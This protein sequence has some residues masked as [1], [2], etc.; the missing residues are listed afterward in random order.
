MHFI[1][2][3]RGT[4][5]EN[6]ESIPTCRENK[7]NTLKGRFLMS[8][9]HST[10]PPRFQKGKKKKRERNRRRRVGREW[11]ILRRS[12]EDPAQRPLSWGIPFAIVYNSNSDE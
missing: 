3:R 10:A 1:P 7:K 11:R 6:D 8:S 12:E 5:V 4:C 9:E 2:A